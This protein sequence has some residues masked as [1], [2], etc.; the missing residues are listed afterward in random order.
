MILSF[1]VQGEAKPQGSKRGF[2]TK[3]GKV[4]MVEMAGTALKSW[5]ETIALTAQIE[6]KKQKWEITDQ[7]ISIEVIF[8][9]KKPQK[10]K[11]KKG[12]KLLYN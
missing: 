10:P 3:S 5:R 7:P 4:A 2:V 1:T 8:Y 11:A 12:K 6:A 9:M